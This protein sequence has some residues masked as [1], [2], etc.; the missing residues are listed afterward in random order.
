MRNYICDH[1]ASWN[2]IDKHW[3]GRRVYILRSLMSTTE[4]Y[5]KDEVRENVLIL[6]EVD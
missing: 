6:N 3:K 2:W 5:I 4:K 1:C